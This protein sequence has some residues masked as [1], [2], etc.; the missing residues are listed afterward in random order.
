MLPKLEP[1]MANPTSGEDSTPRCKE[2]RRGKAATALRAACG[3]RGAGS[4]FRS[5]PCLTTAA[6]SWPNSK[7]FAT[8]FTL[9]LPLARAVSLTALLGLLAL[10]PSA[11]A[12]PSPPH[13]GYVYPAGGRQGAVFQV[14]VGGQY[15]NNATNAYISGPGA[16]A[17]VVDYSRPLTQK[18]FNELRDR[19]KELQDRRAA[20]KGRGRGGQAGSQSGT[21]VVWTAADEKMIAEMR[22][23][24]FLFAPRRNPNPAIAETVTVRVTLAPETEPGERELRL[25][26]PTG[27]SN[28]LRFCVGQL[29]E[30]NKREEQ[31]SPDA[32]TVR[33]RRSNNEPRAVAPTEMEIVLPATVNGQTLPGGVD[34]YRFQAHKGLQ[35]V[36]VVAARELIPYLPDAVPGWFQAAVALYDGKGHEL[37]H[38]DHYS[39]H[40]DPV[41][42]YE[43]PRDG[44]YAVEIRDSIYRGREDFVYR[45]TLG[46]LPY[47]TSIFPLGGPAGAQTTVELKGWNLPVN[48][49]TQTNAESG[50]SAVSVR[51]EGRLSNRVPFA[52]DTLPECLEQEPNDTMATAQPLTL[53]IIVNGR[54]HQPGDWDVFRFEGHAGD[55]V[56]AEVYARRLD[57]PL[58]SALKLTDA[59][60]KQ[61]AF[62]DDYEDKGAGLDTHY[63]DSYITATLPADG[64]YYLHLG[65]TQHQ[66]GSEYGYRLRLSPPRPDFALRVAPSSV[67]VRGGASVPLTVYAL[68]R[69]GFTNEITLALLDAPTGFKLTGAKIPASQDQLRL[70]LMAPPTPTEVPLH[71]SLEGRA[72]VGGR[73]IVRP[74]IPAE[75]MMQ[76]FAYRHLVPAQELDVAVSGR[77]MNRMP[78]KILSA[79]PVKI[80]VGGTTRVRVATP[81]SA[82]AERFR[83]ELN[84]PPEGVTLG[85]VAAVS[86]GVEIELCGDAAKA[87]PGRKGNLIINIF[88]GQAQMAAKKNKKQG[89]QARAAVGT[90]P[91]IPFELVPPLKEN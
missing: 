76:A 32:A 39:Y 69:D 26:T 1:T 28:P 16:Q 13:I 91:A 59:T 9:W 36:V 19:L 49:I 75:D 74:A 72:L 41:L 34:R 37:E 61:L 68:R 18:E 33:Q 73:S 90:L 50:S 48:T 43:I 12:Q 21:N 7:R 4:R 65:D 67:S 40:P 27:L 22:Q 56:V 63:A 17:V 57:S 15:L 44:E 82:F 85:K 47:I 55:T 78:L 35:L 20:A 31:L 30:Y 64:A 89:N 58:D 66:G 62:N 10:T 45:I 14:A 29:V 79:T 3:V 77:F 71:L 2:A 83:L 23:K 53:P 46:E 87:K 70:T 6:A 52:V 84:E 5:G 81:G 25:A 54:I 38:A 8:Q 42:H 88:Q 86:E 51:Q 24:L 60:G 80:P 11:R